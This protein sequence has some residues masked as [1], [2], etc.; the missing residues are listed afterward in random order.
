MPY[1]IGHGVLGLQGLHE[2]AGAVVL[3]GPGYRLA[4][5]PGLHDLPDREDPR[6]AKVGRPG[7]NDYPTSPLG[8]TVSYNG[9]LEGSSVLAM[10][11][12]GQALRNVLADTRAPLEILVS[13]HEDDPNADEDSPTWSYTA[14]V[15]LANV[16]D[17]WEKLRWTRKFQV[18]LRMSDART[19]SQT[20]VSQRR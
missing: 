6:T 12:A 4:E 15:L 3:N 8:K 11:E 13:P 9:E 14:K 19:R 7:E 1:R 17:T 10:L 18:G 16:P 20:R 2:L 5:I